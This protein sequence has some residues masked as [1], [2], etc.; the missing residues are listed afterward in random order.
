[1]KNLKA[2][3]RTMQLDQTPLPLSP[4]LSPSL[5]PTKKGHDFRALSIQ[6]IT[7]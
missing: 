6:N 3:Y 7:R 2:S 5:I 4:S 1:M